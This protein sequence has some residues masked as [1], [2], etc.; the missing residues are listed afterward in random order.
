MD[1]II[2]IK[3]PQHVSIDLVE[4][5]LTRKVM[6]FCRAHLNYQQVFG[7]ALNFGFNLSLVSPMATNCMQLILSQ[8]RK[9]SCIDYLKNQN[10]KLVSFD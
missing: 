10:V 2:A 3:F 7:H 4:I 6:I 1:A 5:M 8:Q 9:F